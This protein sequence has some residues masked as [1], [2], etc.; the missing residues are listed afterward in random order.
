MRLEGEFLRIRLTKDEF[1][2]LAKTRRI[3]GFPQLY[4]PDG[5]DY[6]DHK[7]SL[8]SAPGDKISVPS[9]EMKTCQE[10]RMKFQESKQSCSKSL[11]ISKDL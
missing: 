10:R 4:E 8:I 3:T 7:R 5:E 9:E 6:L 11:T 2:E 1:K